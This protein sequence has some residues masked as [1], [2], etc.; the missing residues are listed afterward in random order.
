[1]LKFILVTLLILFVLSRV[2]GFLFR[3]LFRTYGMRVMQEQ[4]RRQQQPPQPKPPRRAE[5][6]IDIDFVPADQPQ[7]PQNKPK[8]GDYVDYEE[9]K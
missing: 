3:T 2:V 7:R 4:Q 8:S 5:G 6:V 1:M 9:V